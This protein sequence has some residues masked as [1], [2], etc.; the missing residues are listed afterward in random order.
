MG[1]IAERRILIVEKDAH[2]RD[3]SAEVLAERGCRVETVMDGV[4]ALDAVDRGIPDLILVNVSAPGAL[5]YALMDGLRAQRLAKPPRVLMTTT[6]L[7][8]SL[9]RA[10]SA[11]AIDV[12]YQ[13]VS[14]YALT[15]IVEEVLDPATDERT[16]RELARIR[17]ALRT[18]DCVGCGAAMILLQQLAIA[19]LPGQR[20]SL[21][22]ALR[23]AARERLAGG[24]VTREVALDFARRNR[25]VDP[26][27]VA[28]ALAESL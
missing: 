2:F 7:H 25:V 1:S 11:G 22:V 21:K 24:P 6:A 23:A 15:T 16:L 27:L 17:H 12:L 3:F 10:H 28:L 9:A 19:P 20:R 4:A 14:E 5:A 8:H 13:P 18:F 26:A